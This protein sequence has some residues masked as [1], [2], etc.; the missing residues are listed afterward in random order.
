MESLIK[1]CDEWIRAGR[2]DKAV[3]LLIQLKP[4]SLE[5]RFR[6][7]LASLC[8]RTNL[9]H[10][11]LRILTPL[12]LTET[13][14][15]DERA[16]YALL[17]QRAGAVNEAL[18]ILKRLP[19]DANPSVFLY[20]SYCLFNIWEYE[21]AVPLLEAYIA[22]AP[23]PYLALVG[24][25]NLASA[26]LASSELNA[27]EALLNEILVQAERDQSL[28]LQANALE[29][30]AQVEIQR[31]H[32][33]FA[34]D[35]LDRAGE[36]LGQAHVHDQLFVLKWRAINQALAG[37]TLE[38]LDQFRNL[39]IHRREPE[40]LREIDFY[41]L[42]IRPGAALFNHLYFGTPFPKYRA[43]LVD[44]NGG[45]PDSRFFDWGHARG[46]VLDL[47]TDQKLG[48]LGVVLR[49]LSRDFYRPPLLAGLFSDLFPQESFNIFSS[50]GRLRQ[51]LYRTR[52]WLRDQCLPLA[53]EF[54]SGRY[55]LR[56]TAPG[57]IRVPVAPDVVRTEDRRIDW[58][59]SQFAGRENFTAVDVE[60][61]LGL[62]RSTTLRVLKEALTRGAIGKFGASKGT[63]YFINGRRAA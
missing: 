24:R 9:V 57:S 17:L 61:A 15:D 55:E 56:F 29:M 31:R 33:D 13:A 36:V 26:L 35:L 25:V 20:Q 39:A 60:K 43:K 5:Y 38:P 58:L 47:T 23:S 50:P 3:Q 54:Q 45:G 21:A 28:R 27:A 19:A 53:I 48:N 2:P 32:H 37:Q 34:D 63:I 40:V 44:L 12:M 11:G 41:S 52:L 62:S 4:R 7:P 18:A 6:L 1:N 10:I 42:S 22:R 30:L 49:A 51:L 16:E 14:N 46:P 8:R 59:K